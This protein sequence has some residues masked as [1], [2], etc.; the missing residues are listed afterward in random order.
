MMLAGTIWQREL[1]EFAQR[2]RALVIK[3]A[4]PLVFGIPLVIAAPPLYAA[5]TLTMLI[6]IIGA[7]GAGAVLTRERSSGLTLRYRTLPVTPGRLLIERLSISA[8]IDLMQL[9][10]VLLLIA[11]RH[12]SEFAWWPALLLS[13]AA[14]L[15]IGN[16]M[17]AVA[18]TLSDSPGEVMLYV[19]IPLLPL[20]YLSGVFTPLT[21]PALLVVSR[22][23]PFS[24]LHESLL[25]ALGGQPNLVPW[26]T[27]VGGFGFL[28]GA[29]GLTGRLGRRVLESD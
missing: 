14:V 19:F 10:P 26:E 11:L 3:L 21:Q 4:F 22:F 16:L 29:A 17:G 20:L 5:I 7:L 25:G 15:L 9:T 23:L 12:P 8:V 18:S 13:T 6:A 28:V 2:R 27:I 1:V 24:Y